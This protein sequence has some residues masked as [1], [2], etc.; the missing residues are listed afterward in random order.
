MLALALLALRLELTDDTAADLLEAARATPA[1][2][3]L[4]SPSCAY[5]RALLPNWTSVAHR[6]ENDSAVILA[7]ADCSTDA[8][9]CRA[10]APAAW[11][12]S[13]WIFRGGA[14][15]RVFVHGTVEA[16]AAEAEQL[17]RFD[18][19]LP[20]AP[21]LGERPSDYPVFAVAFPDA[22]AAA[23]A[24]LTALANAVPRGAGRFFL[25]APGPFALEVQLSPA[26]S[27]DYRGPDDFAAAAAYA[28]DLAHL[29][30]TE[31][32]IAECDLITQRRLAFAVYAT[33]AQR[34]ALQP[35]AMRLADD[36]CFGLMEFAWFD[37][38]YANSGVTEDDMPIVL[39]LNGAHTRFKVVHGLLFD[40]ANVAYFERL[41][42]E[43]DDEHMVFEFRRVWEEGGAGAAAPAPAPEGAGG[44]GKPSKDGGD[45]ADAL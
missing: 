41:A 5:C 45:R 40:D 12:P 43:G 6:Y 2:V 27:T 30:G 23:C 17:A 28:R 35:F 39:L 32:P 36:F 24:R 18:G 42:N 16:L 4:H 20:C 15:A 3:L 14:P 1:F 11:V 33:D 9:A 22:P 10:V 19:A 13:L 44:E 7:D 37:A 31:W 8:G 38:V 29:S 25:A 26:W 34:A 21:W